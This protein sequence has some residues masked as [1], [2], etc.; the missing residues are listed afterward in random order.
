MRGTSKGPK[1]G[2]SAFISDESPEG[3]NISEGRKNTRRIA[4]KASG[5]TTCE[6]EPGEGNTFA[7]LLPVELIEGG[8]NN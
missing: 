5:E 7:I 3:D 2:D 6:R 8:E 4:V 1:T